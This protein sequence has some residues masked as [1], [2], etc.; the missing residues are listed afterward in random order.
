MLKSSSNYEEFVAKLQKAIF[1][2]EKFTKQ[3]NIIIGLNKKIVDK[4]GVEREFDLYWEYELGGFIYKTII[5]CKDYAQKVSIE[6]ID[7]LL[8]KLHDIPEI[9]GIFAT[10]TGYQ[11]GAKRKAK[12]NNID[13]LIVREQNDSDWTDEYGNPL[14][15]I[16]HLEIICH[17]PASIYCFQSLCD[18]NWIK[19]N[20]SIDITNPFP[21]KGLNNEIFIEDLEKDEIFSLYDLQY[22]LS[23][24][25]NNEP[26]DYERIFN[27]SNGYV[28]FGANKIKICGYKVKYKVHAPLTTEIEMDY[29]KELMGVIEYIQ[30]GTKRKILKNGD[31]MCGVS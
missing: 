28:K 6:K 18:I 1:D 11:S 4:N 2:S 23:E 25:E 31:I 7:A 5:E 20:T 9:R 27:Y 16:I 12:E 29:S 21:I 13:L 10:K 17:S 22:K 24:L 26:G 30:K 3:K 15:K 8:G 19:E 14:L